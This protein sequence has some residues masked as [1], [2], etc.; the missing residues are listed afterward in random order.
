MTLFVGC[1]PGVS[2]GQ[3]FTVPTGQIAITGDKQTT[4]T[5]D[6]TQGTTAATQSELKDIS[7]MVVISAKIGSSPSHDAVLADL[8]DL[9]KQDPGVKVKYVESPNITSDWEPNFIAAAEGGYDLT[10]CFTARSNKVLAG[11]AERYPNA[12]Y[13]S[14][15]N[16]VVGLKNV[17]NVMVGINHGCY[18]CGF[19]AGLMTTR[20]EIPH[21]N[22]DLKVGYVS[23]QDTPYAQDGLVGFKKGVYDANPDVEVVVSYGDSFLDAVKLK[24]LAIAQIQSGVDVFY[25]MAGAGTFG[26]FEA[27]K[28][29]GAYTFGNATYYDDVAEGYVICS[30]MSDLKAGVRKVVDDWRRGIW[31]GDSVYLGTYAN[32][33]LGLSDFAYFKELVGDKFPQDIIDKLVPQMNKI[34]SGEVTIPNFP[35]YY[36]FDI[37]NYPH[38][39]FN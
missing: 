7:I 13:I 36:G 25:T 17:T 23:G 20:T 38:F 9:A 15:D 33:G 35:D 3:D 21:I 26:P 4:Q 5:A 8:Q 39:D 19:I 1:K 12:K 28:E 27:C 22:S 18:M 16:S 2:Q 32:G 30:Y 29:Y 31:N 37:T 10:V 14:V 11:V 24:E 6:A 34:A